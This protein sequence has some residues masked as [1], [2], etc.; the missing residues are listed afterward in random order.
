MTR[1]RFQKLLR[2]KGILE[3]AAVKK[4]WCKNYA[5]AWKIIDCC[6]FTVKYEGHWRTAKRLELICKKGIKDIGGFCL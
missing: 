3:E 6:T 5:E 1:K 4:I 2:S